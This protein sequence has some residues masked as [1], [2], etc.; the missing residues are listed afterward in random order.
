[1]LSRKKQQED[2][3]TF[4][5]KNILWIIKEILPKMNISSFKVGIKAHPLLTIFAPKRSPAIESCTSHTNIPRPIIHED[6]NN[7]IYLF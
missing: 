3:A 5:L 6:N 2:Q 4:P 1:M 7:R